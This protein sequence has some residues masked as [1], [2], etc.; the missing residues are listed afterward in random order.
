[1]ALLYVDTNVFLDLVLDRKNLFGKDLAGPAARMFTRAIKCEFYIAVSAP[2]LIEAY[3]QVNPEALKMLLAMIEKKLVP[4][5]Y[6]HEDVDEAKIRSSDNFD[7][8]LHIVLAEKLKAD[9]IITRNVDHFMKI[10]T[11]IPIEKPDYL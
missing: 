3:R 8:A 7:D 4:V 2:T 5:R 10:G 6:T 9:K 1:M 11:K